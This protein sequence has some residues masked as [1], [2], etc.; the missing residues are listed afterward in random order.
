MIQQEMLQEALAGVVNGLDEARV[1][2]AIDDPRAGPE[3]VGVLANLVARNEK[4]YEYA[5]TVTVRRFEVEQGPE[6]E[7][8]EIVVPGGGPH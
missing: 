4:G 1:N 2:R 5:I 6:E 8:P 3:G 7:E